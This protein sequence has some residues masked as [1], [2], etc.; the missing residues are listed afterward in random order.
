MSTEI[1]QE[2]KALGGLRDRMV[3]EFG[4]EVGGQR[5]ALDELRHTRV[6][7]GRHLRHGVPGVAGRP[8]TNPFFVLATQNPI[9]QEGTYALPEAQ[10]DRFLLNTVIQYP[11]A[12]EEEDIVERT[13]FGTPAEVRPVCG[14][15]ELLKYQQ[16]IRSIP[17]S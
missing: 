15:E 2:L 17:V 7:G 1:E 4:K 16:L 6:A 3:A 13:T 9:D 8:I 10:K 14:R 5:E 11:K 12:E